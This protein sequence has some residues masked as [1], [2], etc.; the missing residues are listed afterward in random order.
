MIKVNVNRLW[1]GKASIRDYLVKEAINNNQDI[2]IIC[3]DEN[4]TMIVDRKDL[5]KG[6]LSDNS[7]K[8]KHDGRYYRLVDY[9][10]SPQAIQD[11]LL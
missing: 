6:V 11:K 9:D 4:A 10:W 7:F 3:K 5:H 1:H 2:L 8:S